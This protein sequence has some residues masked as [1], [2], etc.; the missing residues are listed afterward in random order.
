M[1]QDGSTP[2]T[3]ET[4][5]EPTGAAPQTA[6]A[7][8]EQT[9]AVPQKDPPRTEP[10]TDEEAAKIPRTEVTVKQAQAYFRKTP[11]TNDDLRRKTGMSR[12]SIDRFWAEDNRLSPKSMVWRGIAGVLEQILPEHVRIKA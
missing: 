12:S 11:W 9:P 3:D 1:T 10:L 8:P 4:P 5:G 2:T 7:A 6:H